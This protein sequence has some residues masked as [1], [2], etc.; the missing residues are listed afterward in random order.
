M[1]TGKPTGSDILGHTVKDAITKFEGVATGYCQ[2]LTG[3]NQV[4]VTP[5][6]KDGQWREGHW[7]DEQRLEVQGDAR[8]HPRS[9]AGTNP[10]FDKP[11]PVR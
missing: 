7:I 4:L 3:C 1:I 6:I 5:S 2:Y 8:H 9:F 11:A 10:G